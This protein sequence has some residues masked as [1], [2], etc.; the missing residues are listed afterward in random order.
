THTAAAFTATPT[1]S[2]T[3]T[4]SPT[5]NATATRDAI[6]AAFAADLTHTA[7][8]F[9]ATP[10][11]SATLTPTFTRMPSPTPDLSVTAAALAAEILSRTACALVNR[12]GLVLPVLSGPYAGDR[13]LMTQ[14]PLLAEVIQSKTMTSPNGTTSRWLQVEFPSDEGLLKGWVPVPPD[15]DL[16]KLIAG[17]A[18]P[19]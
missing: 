8:A 12:D 13:Q 2:A 4:P 11:P 15:A 3:L 6:I 7:A 16:A 17:R 5:T 18:C 14:A 9:T 19:R 10:T 1:P